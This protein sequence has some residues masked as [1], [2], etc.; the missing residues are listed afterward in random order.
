MMFT[1]TNNGLRFMVKLTPKGRKNALCGTISSPEGG[2]ILKASVTAA[3]E[4]GKANE[5]LIRLLSDSW[6]IPRA[7]FCLTSGATSRLKG[8]FISGNPQALIGQAEGWPK[9]S[10][11]SKRK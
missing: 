8:L 3:P 1:P 4:D 2:E 10:P 6:D 7:T 5:A 9:I 11:G